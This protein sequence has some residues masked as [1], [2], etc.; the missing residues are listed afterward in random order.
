MRIKLTCI[1]SVLACI[2]ISG[3][4]SKVGIEPLKFSHE[5]EFVRHSD[6]IVLA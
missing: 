5:D 6:F 1:L 4:Q 3:C 2:I